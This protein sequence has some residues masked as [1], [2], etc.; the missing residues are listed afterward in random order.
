MFGYLIYEPQ[1]VARNQFFVDELTRTAPEF[2]M[3]LQLTTTNQITMGSKDNKP[4]LPPDMPQFAIMRCM[5]PFLSKQ[6]ERAGVQVFNNAR[7]AAI[8][9]D[10]RVTHQYFEDHHIP[11]MD[12][13]YVSLDCPRHPFAYPVVLKASSGCGG[14]QVYL[15][16][17]EASYQE[18]L[19]QI[20]PD[21]AVVQPICDTVGR[22]VRLYILNGKFLQAMERYTDG[23]FRS[24]FG[25][26]GQARPI[27]PTTWQ[28]ETA[29]QIASDLGATLIGVDFLQHQGK[30][31]VNEIEDAVGTRMLYQYTRHDVP[32]LYLSAILE[33]ISAL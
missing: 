26:H 23:D 13:A 10:K 29:E 5:R 3:K 14:R 19:K 15:C 28:Q 24:N 6:L 21:T 20:F 8:C 16:P 9:D 31:I 25:L 32:R 1:E 7:T 22:D 18:H 27:E 12:T 11:C 33:K 17:D 4:I 30:W 2:G